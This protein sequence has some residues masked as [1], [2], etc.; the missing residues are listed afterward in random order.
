MMETSI[1]SSVDEGMP[2]TSLGMA[3]MQVP[4]HVQ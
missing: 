1:L 3:G 2:E 4:E